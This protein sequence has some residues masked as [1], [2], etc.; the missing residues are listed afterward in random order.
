MQKKTAE[1][2]SY[3]RGGERGREVERCKIL[4]DKLFISLRQKW[5]CYAKERENNIQ[6]SP[7]GEV[8]SYGYLPRRDQIS[9]IK[10]KNVTFCKLKTSPSRTFVHSL[11]TFRG[12]CQV[13]FTILLQIQHENKFLPTSEHRQAKVRRFLGICLYDCFI[14]YT[15]FV[16][17]KCLETRHHLGFGRKTVN[18]QRYS[19]LR[20]EI[21]TRQN[22]FSLI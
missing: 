6:L 15:N 8:N 18:S 16:F 1:E 19:E 3:K 14:Y 21:K 5:C 13:H 10:P 11:Q 20:E 4:R 9:W 17:Q 2:I 22:Y 12:L 7:E